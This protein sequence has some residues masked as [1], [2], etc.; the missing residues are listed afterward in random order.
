MCWHKRTGSIFSR[1]M[2]TTRSPR[3]V[4]HD[5]LAYLIDH[6]PAN[7]HLILIT[8]HDPPLPLARLRARDNLSEFRN[9]EL[10][11][12]RAEIQR[13]FEQVAQ[14]S[15]PAEMIDYLESRTEGWCAG[16]RLIT[17]ALLRRDPQEVNSFLQGLGGTHRPILDYLVSDVLFAQP[18]KIQIFLLQ[19]CFLKRLTGSLCDVVTGSTDSSELL[20]SLEAANVF[21]VAWGSD[22]RYNWYRYHPLFAEAMQH[23]AQ[24]QLNEADHHA[25]LERASIWYE[26]HGFL[27]EAVDTALDARAFSR[28]AA[29]IEHLIEDDFPNE[30]V[31]LRGWIERLPE[32]ILSDHPEVAFAYAA[33]ILFTPERH[34][35]PTL[36]AVGRPLRMAEQRWEA[37]DKHEQLGRIAALRALTSMWQGDMAAAYA[38]AQQALQL[39]PESSPDMWRGS[40]LILASREALDAGQLNAAQRF[41]LEARALN[42]AA[43]NPDG[44]RAATIIHGYICYEQG[45]LHQAVHL[46]QQILIQV[47]DGNQYEAISDRGYIFWGLGLV[48]FEWNDLETAHQHTADAARIGK[49]IADI[50][51]EVLATILLARVEQAQGRSK[52]AQHLLEALV[53]AGPPGDLLWNIQAWQAQLALAGNNLPLVELWRA[54]R[55]WRQE[56]ALSPALIVQENLLTARLHLLNEQPQT[57]L[58]ILEQHCAEAHAAGWMRAELESLLLMVWATHLQGDR[59]HSHTLLSRALALAQPEN[60]RRP[61]LDEGEPL[62]AA[63]HEA[64]ADMQEKQLLSFARTLLVD[65]TQTGLRARVTS[66]ALP[67]PLSAQ[68]KRVLRLLAAGLSNREI[69]QELVV[70]VNTIKSQLKSIYRKLNVSSRQEAREAAHDFH[71]L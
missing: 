21:L 17:L 47:P 38:L 1:W 70:S 55:A 27:A 54:R 63:I 13:F 42:E 69:A 28:A 46:L 48:E 19:T 34:L 3:Q 52:Q 26:Q 35:R 68:E 71:L 7:L 37:E 33:A 20:E 44:T 18:E 24:R 31:T 53:S 65:H 57:A 2:I 8:R 12:S 39:I 36:A 41:V 22:N 56:T 49:Q 4:V 59:T 14:L 51:L 25:Q 60:I 23:Y 9:D 67:D 15:L 43:R 45:Q 6:L 64:L 62:I 58:E 29:L 10:R 30:L 5:S 61:F 11:F 40:A 66:D 16:L 32:E 50:H